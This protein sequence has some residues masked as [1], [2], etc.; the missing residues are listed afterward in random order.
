M[1]GRAGHLHADDVE[2]VTRG[3]ERLHVAGLPG[4][5]VLGPHVPRGNPKRRRGEGG[6]EG[7]GGEMKTMVRKEAETNE[8]RE[9]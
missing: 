1:S 3:A 4:L 5:E 6:G 7:R 2:V 9:I 8:R